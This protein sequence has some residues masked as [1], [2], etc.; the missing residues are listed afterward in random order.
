MQRSQNDGCTNILVCLISQ[1]RPPPSRKATI[2]EGH[3][4]RKGESPD[5][6]DANTVQRRRALQSRAQSGS[7]LALKQL[8]TLL[9]I[10]YT[11]IRKFRATFKL[12]S[13]KS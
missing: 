5:Y 4:R 12:Y 10:G 9:S 1:G 2:C 6:T 11:I 3:R 7:E 8:W 13:P